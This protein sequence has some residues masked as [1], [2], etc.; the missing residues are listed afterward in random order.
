MKTKPYEINEK[1]RKEKTAQIKYQVNRK[2]KKEKGADRLDKPEKRINFADAF[3]PLKI[4]NGASH[5]IKIARSLSGTNSF[6][7]WRKRKEKK[8]LRQSLSMDRQN[9]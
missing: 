4:Y 9:K 8:A 6:Q 5:K 2:R 7:N 3:N 1:N